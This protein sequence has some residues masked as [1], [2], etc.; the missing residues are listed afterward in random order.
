MIQLARLVDARARELRTK[1]DNEVLAVERDAYAKIAQSVFATQGDAAYPD[2]TFTLRMSYGQVKGYMEN[3]KPV[4]PFTEIRGLFIRGDEHKHKPPYKI[5][6]SWMK[7]RASL[8][9]TTQYNFVSTN[10][11][12]GGNS[13]SPVINVKGELVG[14]IFDGNIQSLPGY[15]VY[16]AAVNRAVSVDSRGMLEALRKVYNA[17]WVADELVGG[18]PSRPPPVRFG[19]RRLQSSPR[20]SLDRTSA[21]FKRADGCPTMRPVSRAASPSR[22]R[23]G[24]YRIVARVGAGGMGEVFKAWDPGLSA[25][26][27]SSCCIPRWRPIPIASAAWSPKDAPPAR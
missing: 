12:V 1:Y 4:T 24:P 25:M 3:G 17:N 13:G 2:G 23:I 22:E 11:I 16:D 19:G 14:L 9:P 21:G 5:A 27:R 10:D 20:H 26:S 8:N 7:A 15:F 6:D 18:A